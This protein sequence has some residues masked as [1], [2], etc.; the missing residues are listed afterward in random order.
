MTTEIER[1]PG[2]FFLSKQGEL[3]AIAG[4][5]LLLRWWPRITPAVKSRMRRRSNGESGSCGEPPLQEAVARWQERRKPGSKQIPFSR[6][7]ESN[8]V[9]QNQ[10]G[11]IV[12]RSSI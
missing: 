2:C 3:P 9:F 5:L 4:G 10:A 7:D 12:F 8:C 6:L 11:L 1:L